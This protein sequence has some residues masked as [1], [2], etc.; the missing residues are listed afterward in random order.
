[1]AD[2][3]AEFRSLS[4]KAKL[5]A[6]VEEYVNASGRYRSVA[7][8]FSEAGRLRLEALKRRDQG[9]KA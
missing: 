1:M 2:E 6:E 5:V 7:E 4:I 3:K 9:G 8:F